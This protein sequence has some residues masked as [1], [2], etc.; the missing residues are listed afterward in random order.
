MDLSTEDLRLLIAA[1]SQL[2]LEYDRPD[3]ANL[4]ERARAELDARSEN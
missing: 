3:A 4:A 1:L 2:D